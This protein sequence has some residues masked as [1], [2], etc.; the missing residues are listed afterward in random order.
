V[1]LDAGASLKAAGL[2]VARA[3]AAEPLERRALADHAYER[4]KGLI[5]DRHIAPQ[6]W[7]SID[8]LAR[9]LGVS[10]TPVREALARLESD[11]L[12]GKAA[13][14][15]Y[16]T[17]PLL[18]RA[19]F[20]QLYDVRLQLEPF[21]AGRAARFIGEGALA[22][23]R[24][25]DRAMRHAPTGSVY[26]DFAQFTAGNAAFHDIVARAADNPFLYDAIYR[27]HSHHRLAQ[28][29][30]YRGI[31]DAAPAIVEHAAILEAIAG[32][33]E[34]RASALMR[35]H[36]ERSRHELQALIIPD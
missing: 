16:R 35:T 20:D 26:A 28:L 6:S 1:V 30:L 11:G 29:Y 2:P 34:E 4:L 32:R 23:L 33:D 17:E 19:S 21:A 14:G 15:R 27:L 9:D 22:Q 24:Q 36:I 10:P 12:V 7:M 25:A 13:N 8:T 18:T 5:L 31:V 3:A